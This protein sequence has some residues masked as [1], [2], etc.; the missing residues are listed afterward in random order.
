MT[1]LEFSQQ[2]GRGCMC[3]GSEKERERGVDV[4]TEGSS[5]WIG[6]SMA[7]HD[8]CKETEG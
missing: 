3:K 8:E 2:R 4:K 7:G 6:S 1:E 5:V